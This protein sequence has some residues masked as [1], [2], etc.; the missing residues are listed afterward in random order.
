MSEWYLSYDNEQIGPI[1]LD[2]A[3][4]RASKNPNGWGWREGL[5]EWRPIA[6]I[7]ELRATPAGRRPP[8]PQNVR[9]A[10]DIDFRIIGSEMQFVEI[11][12]DPGESAIAEAGSLMY[13][14]AA[15]RMES[16]FGD[17]SE[18]SGAG[19]FV[20]KLVGAGK[21]LLTGESLF[22]TL[23]THTGQGKAHVAFSAPY[24]GNIIPVT[25]KNVGG[26]LICQKDSFL[27]AA[28]GVSIGIFFQKRILTAL[29][30]GEGFVMQKLDGDGMVFLHAG[31][32]IIERELGP[33]EA[34]H[35]DTGCVVALEPSVGFEVHRAGN[36]KTMLF[37]GEGVFL[38][39]LTGPG[40]VWLQ[41][42]PFTRLAGR[43]LLATRGGKDESTPFGQFIHG[44]G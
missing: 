17:G 18:G 21:R 42:L 11:E 41:S 29:F 19:G 3:I 6:Q 38:A 14:S 30:G 1:T 13:K 22:T 35:V 44:N 10:D 9:T 39:H 36:I 34:L 32:S 31:G 4:A 15:I 24:P 16:I 2:E 23:F 27:C 7:A 43:M 8:P 25:L 12:L 26:T 5:G 28:K 33:G 37:G 40:K 20:E